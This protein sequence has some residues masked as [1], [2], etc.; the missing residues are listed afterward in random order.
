ME[1]KPIVSI[2]WLQLN[3]AAPKNLDL[4]FHLFYKV[5]K[6][7]YSTRHFKIV[8]EIFRDNMRIATITRVPLSKVI[9]ADT[10]LIK[11]DNWL[12]YSVNLFDYVTEFLTLNSLTFRSI[13]RIDFCA[14]FQ[15][16]HNGMVPSTM[17]KNYMA[18]KYLRLGRTTIGNTH[19]KQ[20]ELDL[21]HNG[22]KFGSNLSDVSSYLYN[23]TLQMTLIE[24]KPWIAEK[25][26]QAGFNMNV[27]TW[28]LE[29]SIKDCN[30]IIANTETGE[31]QVL[32][33]LTVL[34]DKYTKLIYGCMRDKHFSF[35]I[36]DNQ[37]KKSRMQKLPLY[38]NSF[39]K[40]TIV[41]G[42][43]MIAA[44]R[45]DKI[46]IK[47]LEDV[48]NDMRGKDF[49]FNID[50]IGLKEK[51]ISICGLENWARYKGLL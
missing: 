45:A 47:K 31:A 23:K 39:S 1:L 33:D 8:E 10:I 36:K 6:L 13:S 28:R 4:K 38:S 35:V 49:N 26:L 48:N 44:K 24:W 5:K 42:S 34:Q 11:F 12:L 21:L 20:I 9:D 3:V 29:I 30:K 40:Y 17:I 32:N 37:A 15:K 2:D 51:F 43:K 25:W 22:L 19:F 50:I 18:G 7:P 16:F 46:F 41:E 14:D 27:D